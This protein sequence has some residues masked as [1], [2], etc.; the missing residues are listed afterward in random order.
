MKITDYPAPE[1]WAFLSERPQI[2]RK[3]LEKAVDC[4]F[5]EVRKDGDKAVLRYAQLFDNAR[6]A[7]LVVDRACIEG[8]AAQ[9]DDSL[10]KA[11]AF[12]YEN[13]MNFHASQLT[14]LRKWKENKIQT[15]KGV[16]CWR[17]TRPIEKVGIYIP[18]GSAPLCSTVLMLGIPAMLAGCKK[19]VLCTPADKDGIINPAILYTAGLVGIDTI[20]RAGGI[21]A[22]AAMTFGT[23]SISRVN[24]IFGPGNQ[25][26]TA[27][28]QKAQLLGTAIDLPAGPS[29]VLIIADRTANPAFVAADLLSQAEHG[30]DSQ[31]LLLSDDRSLIENALS[32]TQ[33]QLALL[34]RKDTAAKALENSKALLM[35][36]IDECFAFSNIYAPEHLIIAT[37][38]AAQQAAK[39]TSAGSVFLGAY[40]CESAGDYA[41]GTNH[42]L[43]TGGYAGSCGG[44]SVESF[45]KYISFQ[46]ITEEGLNNMAGSITAMAAAEG[47]EA[48][49][50]AVNV[51]KQK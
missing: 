42:T 15:V 40:S 27:A 16:T 11:I 14:D 48:H 29:E 21:Q 28:K 2:D 35:Q 18:G 19:I 31:V 3:T 8:A 23:E 12:A 13:I 51:R 50:N 4:I 41:S 47:L 22:I 46:Y 1:T 38:R 10:K 36:N 37:E 5:G 32:E 33:R 7:D 43:P 24:K 9:I 39:V 17:E 44:V 20:I 25:Y 6:Y 26:V 45:I 34:P 30:P 49:A